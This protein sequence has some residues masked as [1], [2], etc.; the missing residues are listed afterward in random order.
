MKYKYVE[1]L[2]DDPNR[3]Y[4][5]LTHKFEDLTKVVIYVVSFGFFISSFVT[6]LFFLFSINGCEQQV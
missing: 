3:Y 6:W 1:F 4:T 2:P 5:E